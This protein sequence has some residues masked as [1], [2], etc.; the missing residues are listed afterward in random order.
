MVGAEPQGEVEGHR[1]TR[2]SA[3]GG[4]PGFWEVCI[5]PGAP[6]ASSRPNGPPTPSRQVTPMR[7]ACEADSWRQKQAARLFR[8][9]NDVVDD[10]CHRPHPRHGVTIL[11]RAAPPT[12]G[13]A[14]SKP[15]H[16]AASTP[17]PASG[18]ASGK[19]SFTWTPSC[20]RAARPWVRAE[21]SDPTET[22]HA[23]PDGGSQPA[24]RQTFRFRRAP[25]PKKFETAG[26]NP[27]TVASRKVAELASSAFSAFG[28]EP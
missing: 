25:R 19:A 8:I 20:H 24:S 9:A 22:Y 5:T 2:P 28:S 14:T 13:A 16:T 4:L 10:A 11:H 7:W 3:N 12:L 26:L 15:H 1:R 18:A 6:A 21:R 23:E 27:Q 17:D